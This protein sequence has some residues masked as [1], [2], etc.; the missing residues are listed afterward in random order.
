MGASGGLPAAFFRLFFQNIHDSGLQSRFR[1][2]YYA[3]RPFF[4]RTP[5]W[6]RNS[7]MRRAGAGPFTEARP[8]DTPAALGPR[9]PM[10]K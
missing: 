10:K 1:V 3:A 6:K 8:R 2:P 9:G 5:L 7:A 4:G